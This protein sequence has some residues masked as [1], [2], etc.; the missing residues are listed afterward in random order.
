MF[1]KIVNTEKIKIDLE[2]FI[3]DKYKLIF[4]RI[5]CLQFISNFYCIFIGFNVEE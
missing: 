2:C 5:Y 1:Q 4:F 3:V